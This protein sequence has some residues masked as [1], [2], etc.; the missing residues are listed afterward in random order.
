MAASHT[1]G[2][3]WLKRFLLRS[4]VSNKRELSG[5]REILYSVT[6][7][8]FELGELR[9]PGPI[10]KKKSVRHDMYLSHQDP[11]GSLTN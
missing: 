4:I 3:A 5:D 6:C 7:L 9:T 10:F 1:A 2:S 11:W 8:P